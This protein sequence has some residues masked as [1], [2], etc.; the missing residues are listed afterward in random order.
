MAVRNLVKSDKHPQFDL[1]LSET[2]TAPPGIGRPTSPIAMSLDE[3]RVGESVFSFAVAASDQLF[4]NEKLPG[5]SAHHFSGAMQIEGLLSPEPLTFVVRLSF[6]HVSEIFETMRDSVML[7]FPCIQTS[8]PIYGGNS[9]GPLFDIRGR[10]CAVHC[11]SYEGSDI[12]F[13]VPIQGVLDLHARAQSLGIEDPVRKNRSIL[14]LAVEQTVLF[15]PPMLDADRLLRSLLRWLWY[16]VKC[17][18]RGERPSTQ[19]HL[20]TA[21][22]MLTRPKG[23][24]DDIP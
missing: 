20:A 5:H 13:H 6:G 19:V 14:E 18:S 3:L 8:V 2:R 15:E 11:T 10:I 1:A 22:P 21:K 4:S 16:A 23:W 17:L 12:A 9:G 24:A 7:P